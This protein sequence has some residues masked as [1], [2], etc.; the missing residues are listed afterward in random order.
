MHRRENGREYKVFIGGGVEEGESVEAAVVR[1]AYEE[2]SLRVK[3]LR[4][5]Y[6]CHLDDGTRH[7]FYLC[8]A[9]EG[10]PKLAAE[11]PEL[12]EDNA[13]VNFYEPGWVELSELPKMRLYPLEVRDWV[14][15]DAPKGWAGVSREEFFERAKLRQEI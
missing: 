12:L 3:L 14:I 5:V 15:E 2:T 6:C 7:D 4:R 9:P 8:E 13:A 11:S 1:E 10:E